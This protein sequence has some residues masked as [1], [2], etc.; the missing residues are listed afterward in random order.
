MN[1]SNEEELKELPQVDYSKLPK[2]I[3]QAIEKKPYIIEKKVKLT[4]GNKQFLIRIPTEIADEMGL[5]SE[6]MILFRLTKPLPHSMD[7][8]Q[9]EMALIQ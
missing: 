1:K 8:P 2:E 6:N 5:T 7:K 3:E 9:M 4:Q